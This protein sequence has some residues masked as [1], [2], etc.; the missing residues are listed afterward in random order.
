MNIT[1]I[2]LLK[3]LAETVDE[4]N[5][6]LADNMSNP[7]LRSDNAC[8]A[9]NVNYNTY[10]LSLKEKWETVIN[11][12]LNTND[13]CPNNLYKKTYTAAKIYIKLILEKIICKKY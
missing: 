4:C 8:M 12:F 10:Y 1:C 5:T 9:F 7:R 2:N 11:N 6:E 3:S 13:Y